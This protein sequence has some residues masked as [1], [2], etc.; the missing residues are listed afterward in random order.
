LGNDLLKNAFTQQ[1]ILTKEVLAFDLYAWVIMPEHFHLLLRTRHED[2]AVPAILRRL[3]SGFAQRAISRWRELDAQILPRITDAQGRT[4]FW[5]QGGGYDRNIY[6]EEEMIEKINYIH[7]N[8]I[9]RGLVENPE[10]WVWS[11]ARWHEQGM[12]YTGPA[13]DQVC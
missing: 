1:L 9:K 2:V 6:S 11:S 7:N 13:I 8:P 4:R 12:T 10:D 3:K 5:Q